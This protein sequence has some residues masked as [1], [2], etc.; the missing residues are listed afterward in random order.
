MV[1][2]LDLD[3]FITTNADNLNI[4]HLMGTAQN[5]GDFCFEILLNR[6][7]EWMTSFTKVSIVLN[8]IYIIPNH[9]LW[10]QLSLLS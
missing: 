6:V 4:E 2:F 7:Y 1:S 3:G 8:Q 9:L 5:E 10:T